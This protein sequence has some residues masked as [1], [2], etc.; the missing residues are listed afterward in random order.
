MPILKAIRAFWKIDLWPEVTFYVTS[1]CTWKLFYVVQDV[2]KYLHANFQGNQSILKIDLWP[3]VTFY[4]TSGC[5]QKR[6][7]VVQ[8][9][10]QYLLANFQ[11][12]Q[13]ILKIWPLTGS[14]ILCDFRMY[15]KMFLCCSGCP[16]VP[17][18]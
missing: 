12:N 17:P 18:C 14:N 13:S 9:V 1:G 15:L 5:T 6:F 11:G 3:E 7:Y 8:D 10:L 16:K 4:V 2:L